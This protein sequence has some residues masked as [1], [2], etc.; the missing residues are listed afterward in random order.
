MGLKACAK[1]LE[2]TDYFVRTINAN[3]VPLDRAPNRWTPK[4]YGEWFDGFRGVWRLLEEKLEIL[5]KEEAKRAARILLG[6]AYGLGKIPALS[7]MVI[8]T[9]R[10]LLQKGHLDQFEVIEFLTQFLHKKSRTEIPEEVRRTWESLREDIAPRDFPSLMKRYVALDLLFDKFDEE[11]RYVDQAQPRIEELARRAV[12]EPELLIP[13]LP[14]LNTV[15]AKRGYD[16]G[17]ALGVA[18]RSKTFSLLPTLL[19]AQR[20]SLGTQSGS[21]FFLGGYFRALH[22]TDESSFEQVLDILAADDELKLTVPELTF[23][24]GITERAAQRIAVQAE[25]GDI[26]FGYLR[27]FEYGLELLGV[28]EPMFQ[29]WIEYLLSVDDLYATCWS[30]NLMSLYYL[31]EPNT[32]KEARPQLASETALKVLTHQSLFTQSEQ[33]IFDQMCIWNW[34]RLAGTF[35]RLYPRDSLTLAG[36]IL[37]N[38]GEEAPIFANL[39]KYPK[40]IL[41]RV[42]KT[43]PLELWE[44]ASHYLGP[45]IDV[46]AWRIKDWIHTGGIHFGSPPE[47]DVAA[48]PVEKLWQWID[49]D[50][51][52]ELGTPPRL[53]QPF[54]PEK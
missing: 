47:N 26:S 1:A 15:E 42:A 13:E 50:W 16:F 5:R 11:E 52:T 46:R 3:F 34:G 36:K 51:K 9:I 22:Q 45:P 30:L 44:S 25:R 40:E 41:T 39:E 21:V 54:F 28:S 24:G 32:E 38:F 17:Y 48:V 31:H 43:Y 6:S 18:D 53:R 23:R 4:T 37:E 27:L 2:E 10:D 20:E 14:W 12:E 29:R 7:E 49:E 35:V 33:R 19:Q 8:A